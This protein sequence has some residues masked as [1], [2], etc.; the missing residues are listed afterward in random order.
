MTSFV[1]TVEKNATWLVFLWGGLFLALTVPLIP[2]PFPVSHVAVDSSGS[3]RLDGRNLI[4]SEPGASFL[5][6]AAFIEGHFSIELAV[7]AARPDEQG[8]AR[9]AAYSLSPAFQNWMIGQQRDALVVRHRNRQAS[10]S[11]VFQTRD[12]QHLTLVLGESGVSLFR[13]GR[14]AGTQPWRRRLQSWDDGSRFT[15][16]NEITNNPRTERIN[17]SAARDFGDAEATHLPENAAEWRKFDAIIIGDVPPASIDE[18]TWETIR[19]CVA[20]RGS[21][22]VVIAGQRYMPHAFDNEVIADLLPITYQTGGVTE[23]PEQ[24]RVELTSAGSSNVILQQSL[25]RSLNKQIWGSIPAMPWRFKSDDVKEGAEVLAY[26][27]PDS[28][29]GTLDLN[30]TGDPTDVEAAL[31]KLANRKEYED[32]NALLVTQRFGLGRVVMLN[33]DS[34]W[35]FRYGVG[36]TYHHRFWGQMMRFGCGENLRSGGEYVRLGTD[37]LSYTPNAPVK[38]VAKVLDRN[39]EPVTGGSVYVRLYEGEEQVQRRQLSYREGSNG[40]FEGELESIPKEGQYRLELEGGPVDRAMNDSGLDKVDTELIVVNT[41]SAIELS[42]L[43]ADHDFMAQTAQLA[44]GAV[45]AID[46]AESL[47]SFFGAAKEVLKERHDT[48]LWDKL[49]LLLLFVGLV[50]AEWILRRRAGLA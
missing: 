35:R 8:P 26:G 44:G 24:F 41:R 19:E 27:I 45:S 21:M 32:D 18:A 47:L 40:I 22:L 30:F 10:F 28:D 34:T 37:Q 2:D 31:E 3:I 48:K 36:D 20:E 46:D 33:F 13:S 49:P 11:G 50:T 17:A 1:A 25:S 29:L 39:R 15:L 9:I 42:E 5:N 6:A 43:T 12:R 14:I 7:A 4:V 38:V 23:N 16:G